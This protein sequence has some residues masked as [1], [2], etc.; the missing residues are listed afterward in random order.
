MKTFIF[1]W[2]GTHK[3]YDISRGTDVSDAFRR[4]G[5]GGGAANALDYY[6]ERKHYPNNCKIVKR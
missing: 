4:L 3:R 2:L 5:Y 1:Y 6:D